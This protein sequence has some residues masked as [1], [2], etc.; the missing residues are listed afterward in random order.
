MKSSFLVLWVGLAFLALLE[1]TSCNKN[2]DPEPVLSEDST[3]V[4]YLDSAGIVYQVDGN[5][6]YSFPITLNPTGKQQSEGKIL[7]IYFELSV[8]DGPLLQQ[9]DATDGDPIRLKQGV[10]AVYPIGVDLALNY[11]AE[12]EEWGFVI[13]SALAYPGYSSSLIPENAIL[14]FEVTL[15]SIQNENDVFIADTM[16]IHDYLDSLNV[17]DTVLLSNGMVYKQLAIGSGGVFPSVGNEVDITYTAYRPYE[18]A[19]PFDL[20]HASAATVFTY[21]FGA[22]VVIDGLDVAVSQMTVGER[23]LH[24]IPSNL[25]YRESVR[26]L[27]VYD[28]L[29]SDLIENEVIPAYARKVGPYEVVIFDVRLLDVR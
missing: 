25:G 10:N 1:L 15:A 26:V 24:I 20:D 11:M 17:M 29:I 3:I 12:G 21:D 27:P 28:A 14:F 23:A 19:T 5:G 4:A 18:E 22:G 7:G 6:I 13:P 9:Y 8:L 2:R 16:L